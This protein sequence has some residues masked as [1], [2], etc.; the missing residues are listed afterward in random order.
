VLE[1][2]KTLDE[3]SEGA[4]PEPRFAPERPG[5]VRRSCLDVGRARDE[6]GWEPRVGL[7]AGLGTILG[8]P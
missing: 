5:E 2:I 6:L 8:K 4:M 3:V 1:L 7:L